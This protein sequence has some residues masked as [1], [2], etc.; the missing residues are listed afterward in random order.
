MAAMDVMEKPGV[1]ELLSAVHRLTAQ[2]AGEPVCGTR[3]HSPGHTC[4]VPPA[5]VGL[6]DLQ[7]AVGSRFGEPRGL[8][9]GGS[10]D[11][12][13]SARSGL[14]LLTP[15]GGRVVEMRAWAYGDRWIGCGTAR[16]ADGDVRPVV[17][18]AGREDPAAGVP[19]PASWVERVVAVTG[20]DTPRVRTVDWA[21]VEARLGTA[22]PGDYKRLVEIFGGEGAFDGFLRLQVPDAPSAGSD[23]VRHTEWLGEWA[24]TR[25]GGL[26]EPYPVYPAPGGV[27]QWAGTEQADQVYWLTDGPDPDRWPVLAQEDV[28]DSWRRFDGST[29]EFVH[30]LLTDPGHPFST[31]RHFDVH[32]Y[33]S[34]GTPS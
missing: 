19:E 26:W 17:L 8:V 4:L 18:V 3:G 33:Q 31:A 11:P 12:A 27:L 7:E 22:L 23:I 16:A 28:P 21:A 29:G 14:P 25:G 13:A 20:W 1:P 9:A 2:R 10:V 30:R 34:Y 5:G 32:W 15:F 6:P 24:R